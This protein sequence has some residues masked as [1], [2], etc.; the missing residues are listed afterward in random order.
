[1]L[2]PQ[3][4]ELTTVD[5]TFF[6]VHTE[7]YKP[8]IITSHGTEK[9]NS[10][11]QFRR[12]SGT[13][14]YELLAYRTIRMSNL[15]HMAAGSSRMGC[16]YPPLHSCLHWHYAGCRSLQ[17]QIRRTPPPS[18][19]G[20][21][22]PSTSLLVGSELAYEY[23][24]LFYDSYVGNV[25]NKDIDK[26][27]S[28]L[29]QISTRQNQLQAYDSIYN[30]VTSRFDEVASEFNGGHRPGNRSDGRY[31]NGQYTKEEIRAINNI[32]THEGAP[33]IQ[34]DA[35]HNS[36]A[37]DILTN[38]ERQM[39]VGLEYVR[40]KYSAPQ[41]DVDSAVS[42]ISKLN[43]LAN[44]ISAMDQIGEVNNDIVLQTLTIL[45]AGYNQ[46]KVAQEYIVFANDA[47]K[48]YYT[49]DNPETLTKR[50]LSPYD[51]LTDFF[52]GKYPKSFLYSIFF[53][54]LI[55]LGAFIFFDIAFRKE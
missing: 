35:R 2:E 52:A 51:V 37:S 54:I 33:E 40:K 34:Y 44:Q 25:A 47:E 6:I 16:N 48:E 10:M 28:Y 14:R 11:G 13:G 12:I 45:N 21:Y 3:R 15:P 55:D 24:T 8:K 7:L 43:L 5:S 32:L 39:R 19:L 4:V 20:R 17:R 30:L 22:N 49:S 42:I 18:L 46:I 29:S 9:I 38:Y 27:N 50:M 31:G 1:M 23:P 26:T 41:E 53:S 36:T